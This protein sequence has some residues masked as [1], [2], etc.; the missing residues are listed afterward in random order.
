MASCGG[1]SPRQHQDSSQPAP[2]G[3]LMTMSAAQDLTLV[4][5]LCEQAAEAC[6]AWIMCFRETVKSVCVDKTIIMIPW[7]LHA[8]VTSAMRALISKWAEDES[9]YSL[10]L[11]YTFTQAH[12]PHQIGSYSGFSGGITLGGSTILGIIF[13]AFV[14]KQ[15]YTHHSKVLFFSELWHGQLV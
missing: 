11:P 6:S 14:F 7:M 15:A 12:F 4:C 2:P 8:Y 10:R 3:Y 1:L 13:A 5:I 9:S